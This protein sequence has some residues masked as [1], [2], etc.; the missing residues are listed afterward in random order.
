MANISD[1]EAAYFKS[2]EANHCNLLNWNDKRENLERSI[3]LS[4]ALFES[5]SNVNLSFWT[6]L[7]VFCFLERVV[8]QALLLNITCHWNN[9]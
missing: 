9:N 7:I 8:P 4:R 1:A 6:K 3:L 2:S 5:I